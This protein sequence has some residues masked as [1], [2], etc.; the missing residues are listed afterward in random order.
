MHY[1]R[2]FPSQ[3]A[4]STCLTFVLVH[5]SR[6]PRGDP[7]RRPEEQAHHLRGRFLHPL[8]PV[9]AGAGVVT[10]AAAAAL[11]GNVDKL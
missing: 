2:Y 5:L 6:R 9:A 10:A 1:H 4:P 7:A 11:R 3:T 8:H